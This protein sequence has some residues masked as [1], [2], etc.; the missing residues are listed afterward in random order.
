MTITILLVS[1]AILATGL[2]PILA[3]AAL[4]SSPWF[5][6]ALTAAFAALLFIA[7]SWGDKREPYKV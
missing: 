2:A 4:T 1:M 5:S 7:M 6:L 3:E